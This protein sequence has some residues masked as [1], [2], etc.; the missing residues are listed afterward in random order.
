MKSSQRLQGL[1]DYRLGEIQ[2][3]SG[4]NC[5]LS[6]CLYTLP[7]LGYLEVPHIEITIFYLSKFSFELMKAEPSSSVPGGTWQPSFPTRLFILS[8]IMI[9]LSTHRVLILS[10]YQNAM[11]YKKIYSLLCTK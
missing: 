1:Q 10:F 5:P 8:I 11:F 9:S 7:S 3:L 2:E 6:S 4:K